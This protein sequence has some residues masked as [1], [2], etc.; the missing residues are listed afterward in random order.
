MRLHGAVIAIDGWGNHHIDFVQIFEELGKR[1]IPAVG[2]SYIAL[3]GRLVCTNEYT[4]TIVDFNKNE[5]GYESCIVGDNN[6]TDYDAMK[7]IALLKHK[8]KKK[9]WPLGQP[10]Q[11]TVLHRLAVYA[12]TV[13]QV[14]WGEKTEV[15]GTMLMLGH[16]PVSV[17][18]AYASY[19]RRVSVQV[20][21]PGERHQKVHTNL[22]F[23][24]IAA[25]REG[26]LGSGVT[27]LLRGVTVMLTGADEYH[28]HEPSNIGSSEGYLDEQVKFGQNGTP[29]EDDIILHVHVSFQP[30]KDT[31]A[32]GIRCAHA[33][34]DQVI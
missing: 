10:A 29:A 27:Q 30:G 20:I 21:M 23:M 19:V 13:Q 31:A 8:M 2:L 7:A 9:S 34:A 14:V 26:V 1:G 25:K 22:D 24:P 28:G 33:L 6:L 32:Q 17:P 4:E 11:E 15:E 5:S 16:L 12:H 3:Q 18:Q